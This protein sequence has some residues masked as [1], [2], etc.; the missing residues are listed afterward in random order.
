MLSDVSFVPSNASSLAREPLQRCEVKQAIA[1]ES[2]RAKTPF[3]EIFVL[4]EQDSCY[5]VCVLIV[6]RTIESECLGV[7][8]DKACNID[9]TWRDDLLICLPIICKGVR[10]RQR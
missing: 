7:G 10:S 6:N 9:S 2:N 4:E 3:F 8:R 1:D 5:K